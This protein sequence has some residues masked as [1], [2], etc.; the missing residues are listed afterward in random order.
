[1]I[2]TREAQE[3]DV[4]QIVRFVTRILHETGAQKAPLFDEV[5]WRWE[6]RTPGREAL[7]VLAFDEDQIVGA[8]HLTPRTMSLDDK[9]RT[10]V[11]LQDLGVD[12]EYRRHGV[13][14]KMATFAIQ[15]AIRRG[16][17]VT[18]SLPNQRSY[19]GFIKKLGY[20]HV[21]SIPVQ[22]S[23][24]NIG[25]ALGKRLPLGGLWKAVYTPFGWAMQKVFSV[26]GDGTIRRIERFTPDVDPLG[27]AF[28]GVT[29]AGCIRDSDFLNWR[30]IDKPG[31]LYEAYGWYVNNTLRAYTVTRSMQMFGLDC[32][33]LMDFAGAQADLLPLLSECMQIAYKRGIAIAVTMGLHP[34]LRSLKQ[35]GFLT[36]PHRINPRVLQFIVQCHTEQVTDAVCLPTAWTLTLVDWDVL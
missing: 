10:M 3:P 35:L 7:V 2:T 30:F 15:E 26:K 12:A 36:V 8:F 29:G 18:Y 20:T 9:Q 34:V 27:S 19:P 25:T 31:S 6:Y 28:V 23:P 14:V 11:L 1:M 4:P 17:D 16:W 13:F 32:I 22:I 21:A 33:L 24:L 5:F